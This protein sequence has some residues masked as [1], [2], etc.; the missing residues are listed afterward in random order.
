MEMVS[1]TIRYRAREQNIEHLKI[2]LN[3]DTLRIRD[4]TTLNQDQ[5]TKYTKLF[6]F[7]IPF[8]SFYV[9]L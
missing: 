9:F 1:V 8:P 3:N 5:I 6:C 7:L 2:I 4:C